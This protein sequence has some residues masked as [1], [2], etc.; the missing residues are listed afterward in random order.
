MKISDYLEEVNFFNILVYK[1][2][3]IKKKDIFQSV[4]RYLCNLK[5]LF[6]K[7]IVPTKRYADIV[8]P[9]Y[10][11]GYSSSHK[12]ECNLFNYC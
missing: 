12:N 9:N 5:P 3:C 10:G 4:N 11:N 7:H 8:V 6:E 2:V 1:D